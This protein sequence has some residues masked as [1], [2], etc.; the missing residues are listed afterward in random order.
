MLE[1]DDD[2]PVELGD[3]V[4]DPHHDILR[5]RIDEPLDEVEAHALDALARQGSDRAT[6][7]AVIAGDDRIHAALELGE[8]LL[9]VLLRHLGLPAVTRAT[10]SSTPRVTS[11]RTR[12]I[13]QCAVP[14][15]PIPDV[16]KPL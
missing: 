16:G 11:V 9:Q 13:P 6:R 7:R 1:I 3:A 5:R 15:G 10:S 2:L 14:S 8:D 12:W 4:G